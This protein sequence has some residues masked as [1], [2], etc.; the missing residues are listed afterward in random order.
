MRKYKCR[1]CQKFFYKILTKEQIEDVN[2]QK[3]KAR[4]VGL[5]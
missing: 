5:Q 1:S 2:I 4:G 3:R